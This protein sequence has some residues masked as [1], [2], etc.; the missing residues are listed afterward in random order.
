M[1]SIS[2]MVQSYMDTHTYTYNLQMNK[3]NLY[4]K[5]I[6]SMTEYGA[7]AGLQKQNGTKQMTI[8][9]MKESEAC[10]FNSVKFNSN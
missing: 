2:F 1:L 10:F 3:A 6:K 5:T 7:L 4:Q 9:S 8:I